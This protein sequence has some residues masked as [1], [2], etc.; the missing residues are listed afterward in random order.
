ML[1]I[2]SANAVGGRVLI[3]AFGAGST[4]YYGRV[5][6]GTESSPTAT[7][8]A[9]TLA[10]LNGAGFTSAYANPAINFSLLTAELWTSTASGTYAR[11][12]ITQPTTLTLTNV[13]DLVWSGG[14]NGKGALVLSTSALPTTNYGFDD[15]VGANGIHTAGPL[16]VAGNVAYSG[17][18]PAV[19]ACGTNPAIDGHATNNSGTVTVGTVASAASCTVTHSRPLDSQPGTTA[20]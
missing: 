9:I 18:A 13:M 15:Q 19:S 12:A 2:V 17:T 6:G 1:Q 7:P 14:S 11:W 3:D 5:S 16:N 10:S 4:G 20:E 8:N